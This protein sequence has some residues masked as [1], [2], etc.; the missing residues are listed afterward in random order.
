MTKEKKDELVTAGELKQRQLRDPEWVASKLAEDARW[1]EKQA[2]LKELEA[3]LEQE[4]KE[5]GVVVKSYRHVIDRPHNFRVAIPILISHMQMDKYPELTKN[6][7]AQ[8]I[9][10]KEANIYWDTIVQ[11]FK[12]A[13]GKSP[14]FA[15]GLATALSKA[16]KEPQLEQLIELCENES[17]GDARV[18]LANGLRKSKDNR[19]E[20]ALLKLSSDPYIGPQVTKW[21]RKKPSD[22]KLTH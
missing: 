12:S 14:I 6:F 5:S 4:L 21:L 8:A 22:K 9:A 11:I 20:A 10:M 18:L 16:W 7:M 19:A 3:P 15:Q 13:A 2:L 17:Y 1:E